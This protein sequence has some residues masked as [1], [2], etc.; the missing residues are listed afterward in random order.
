MR[1]KKASTKGQLRCVWWW[2]FIM[3]TPMTPMRRQPCFHASV[4]MPVGEIAVVWGGSA[5]NWNLMPSS[6]F[7]FGSRI[8]M[9]WASFGWQTFHAVMCVAFSMHGAMWPAH[10]LALFS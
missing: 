2:F 7:R 10:V 9:R 1:R 5:S 3:S 4:V 6:P 8:S